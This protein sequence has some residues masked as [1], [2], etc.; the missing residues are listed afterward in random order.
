MTRTKVVNG[1]RVEMAEEEWRE[2]L[3]DWELYRGPRGEPLGRKVDGA[4]KVLVDDVPVNER[5]LARQ[6]RAE[7]VREAKERLMAT[8]E[9][10]DILMLLGER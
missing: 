5:A 7:Q 3:A 4:G 8:S 1:V 6:E 10:R 2:A 9:G